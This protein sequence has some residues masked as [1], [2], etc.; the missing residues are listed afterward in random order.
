MSPLGRWTKLKKRFIVKVHY[1]K[2]GTARI[3]LP[4]PLV[5]LFE[6]PEKI[7]YEISEDQRIIIYPE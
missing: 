2:H 4:R 5:K 1:M 7:V 3:T 6:E